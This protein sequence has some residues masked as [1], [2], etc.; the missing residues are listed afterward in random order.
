MKKIVIYAAFLFLFGATFYSCDFLNDDAYQDYLDQQ[1]EDFRKA[2]E[3]YLIDSTLIV[4]YLA[5]NDSIAS[6]HNE[7]G[8]FYHILDEGDNFHPDAYSSIRVW[9]KGMLLDGTVFDQTSNDVTSNTLYL[10]G[11]ISG[12]RIGVPLIGNGGKIILY[13]PSYFAF[14]NV[15]NGDIPANSVLIFEIHLIDFY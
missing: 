1:E 14:G 7:T 2:R 9:Y 15:E 4:N 13:L 5:D 6:Y 11:L 3:Q 10:G 12:W 8:I